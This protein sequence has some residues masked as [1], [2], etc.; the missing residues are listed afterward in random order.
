MF[1]YLARALAVITR[2]LGKASPSVV[3]SL[4]KRFGVTSVGGIVQ[5]IKDRP[6]LIAFVAYELG[7]AVVSEVESIFTSEGRSL[8]PP[9]P[10]SAVR[11]SYQRDEVAPN[12]LASIEAQRD[13]LRAIRIAA[14]AVGGI[15][16]L[17]AIRFAVGLSDAHFELND[18]LQG[19]KL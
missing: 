11:V 4:M 9:T 18:A 13:D 19:V 17:K 1:P 16:N 10:P 6:A 15:A 14:A 7:D 3:S 8:P 5:A 12:L 2:A